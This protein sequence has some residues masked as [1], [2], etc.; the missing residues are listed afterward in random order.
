MWG[1]SGDGGPATAAQ[2]YYP[3]G[4][5][6]DTAGN[7]Y[8][9]DIESPHPQGDAR[10]HDQHRGRE[11]SAGLQRRWRTGDCGAVELSLLASRSI[12]RAISTSQTQ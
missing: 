11:W 4:V 5:A 2:L 7:L 8:I 6:V 3:V 1:Y 10:G 12:L 9:A